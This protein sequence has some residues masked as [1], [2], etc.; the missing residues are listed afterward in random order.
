MA[1]EGRIAVIAIGGGATDPGETEAGL[2]ND[3]GGARRDI[4]D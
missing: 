3:I 1:L 4:C 2:T